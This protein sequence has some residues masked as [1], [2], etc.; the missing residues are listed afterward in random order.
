MP[1]KVFC[2]L[3]LNGLPN[4]TL[5]PGNTGSLLRGMT[6]GPAACIPGIT[7]GIVGTAPENIGGVSGIMPCTVTPGINGELGYMIGIAPPGLGIAPGSHPFG[8]GGPL[9]V[10]CMVDG[11]RAF[12][13]GGPAGVGMPGA[14]HELGGGGP[15]GV[16]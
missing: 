9:G 7:G 6:E 8:G 14:I 12:G 3:G 13:G 11:I 16:L 1:P 15:M 4:E 5:K 2:I 10:L